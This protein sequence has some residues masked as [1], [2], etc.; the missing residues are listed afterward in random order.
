VPRKIE[1]H[2]GEER[3]KN[4]GRGIE[5]DNLKKKMH[6]RLTVRV[7][8]NR[9]AA[10]QKSALGESI[11][12]RT[13]EKKGEHLGEERE[14]KWLSISIECENNKLGGSPMSSNDYED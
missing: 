3:G 5:I 1:V 14:P 10:S 12:P 6:R 11:K 8:V 9:L 2:R 4:K 13:Y 7:E